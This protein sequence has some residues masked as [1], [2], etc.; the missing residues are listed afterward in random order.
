M[1]IAKQIKKV[2]MPAISFAV[3]NKLSRTRVGRNQL[4][5]CPSASVRVCLRLIQNKKAPLRII[6][7]RRFQKNFWR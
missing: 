7:Q 2:K 5:L 1:K 3:K 6:S 4:N